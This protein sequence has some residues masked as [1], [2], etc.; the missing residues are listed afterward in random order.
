MEWRTLQ[1]M[2]HEGKIPN[3]VT[4]VHGGMRIRATRRKVISPLA[5]SISLILPP[6]LRMQTHRESNGTNY[7]VTDRSA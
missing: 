2:N 3:V 6:L 4:A 5:L 7:G 1:D